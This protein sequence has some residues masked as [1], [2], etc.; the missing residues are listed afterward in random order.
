VWNYATLFVE[1][2][3]RTSG[4]RVN[5]RMLGPE[6]KDARRRQR[7]LQNV[8]EDNRPSSRHV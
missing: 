6:R 8:V 1:P 3:L 2:E 5:R 4:G 7:L